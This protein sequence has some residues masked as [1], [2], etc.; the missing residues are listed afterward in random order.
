MKMDEGE[1]ITHPWVN[2]SVERA[3][4]KV[5]QNNFGIRKRQLEYDDVLNAQR[6]VIYDRR[7]SAIHGDRLRGDLMDMLYDYIEGL[8]ETHYGD[9]NLDEIREELL[10]VLALDFQIDR[11]EF[12]RLGEDGL[13]DRIMETAE[14]Y[15][16][17]KR[18]ALA[19]PFL[20][21]MEKVMESDAETKPERVF[22]DF[23]DGRKLMRVTVKISDVI[24]SS[25]QA[26]N[27]ALERVSVLS[28]I[29]EHWTEHL[30][31]LDE[32][33]EGIGLRA[34]GQRDPL[35]EY[36]MEAFK[37]FKQ[38][39]GTINHDVV[40]FIFRAGPLV[41]NNNQGSS[42][43]KRQ[44]V[45]KS[46]LDPRRAKTQHDAP[47][48]SFGVGGGSKGNTPGDRDPSAGPQTVVNN[49][50]VGRNDPCPCGSGKKYKKCHG[51][52]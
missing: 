31:G 39:M 23:T 14:T 17:K 42:A 19:A 18:S 13:R 51:R 52:T 12:S 1:V 8:V 29:D 50:K 38:M 44:P 22:V 2:K 25:G 6:Q 24:D 43:A 3:Q 21:S 28:Y 35:I 40:S 26:I 36:K 37:L 48:P 20:A 32:V 10:R 5:E 30:R 9:G 47:P 4:T 27:D 46:R 7:T 11:E 49:E 34:F 16:N 45:S 33:K 41:N 15:Y